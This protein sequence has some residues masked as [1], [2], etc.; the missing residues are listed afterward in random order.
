MLYLSDHGEDIFD[1]SRERYLHASP[2]PTYYQLHIPYLIWFSDTY[3]AA[4]PDKYSSAVMHQQKPIST[5]SVFHTLLDMAQIETSQSDSTLSL[6]NPAFAVRDRMYLG[7]H[8]EPVL[9]WK[10]GL[11][12][13]DFQ[14]LDKWQIDYDLGK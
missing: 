2:I 12:N 4:F 10:I 3:Q 7:D 8:D 13:A 5:N 6:T 9:F 14:M 11:K 1:D